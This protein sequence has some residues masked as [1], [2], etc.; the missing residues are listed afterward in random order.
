MGVGE[1]FISGLRKADM[2]SVS[3]ADVGLEIEAR[4]W[5][6]FLERHIV[7]SE[8]SP[9]DFCRAYSRRDP[10]ITLTKNAISI[11]RSVNPSRGE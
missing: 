2:F 11:S 4:R 1:G 7:N 10:P 9:C 3:S 6:T 8:A 5:G